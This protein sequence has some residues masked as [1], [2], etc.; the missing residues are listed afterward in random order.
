MYA[1]LFSAGESECRK[2]EGKTSSGASSSL[3]TNFPADFYPIVSAAGR[4]GFFTD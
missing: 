4:G 2:L 3:N 1:L